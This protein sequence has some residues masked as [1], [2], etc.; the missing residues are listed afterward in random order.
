MLKPVNIQE[1]KKLCAE[2]IE[3]Q[4]TSVTASMPDTRRGA[5]N[6]QQSK[7][8]EDGDGDEEDDL[9]NDGDG[10]HNNDG[11][12]VGDGLPKDGSDATGRS[13]RET[14]P[15]RTRTRTEKADFSQAQSIPRYQNGRYRKRVT[16]EDLRA[17]ARFVHKQKRPPQGTKYWKPF[18]G[19]SQVC[20][21]SLPL[22]FASV[23]MDV[24]SHRRSDTLRN[25]RTRVGDPQPR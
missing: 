22:T 24:I 16:D 4:G 20:R 19:D 6:D 9:G 8:V 3:A 21:N 14:R 2:Y 25:F 7:D 10:T 5:N 1:L 12:N 11:K 23:T 15:K 13:L 18:V 17:M